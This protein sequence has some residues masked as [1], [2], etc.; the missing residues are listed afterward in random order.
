MT[1]TPS[2]NGHAKLVQRLAALHLPPLAGKR[3]LEIGCG[4]GSACGFAA[5]LGAQAVVGLDDDLAS[6]AQAR[7]RFGHCE[8]HSL[9]ED[10]LPEGRFDV[11][12]LSPLL[13][14]HA[15][16]QRLIALALA[17]LA[18]DGLLVLDAAVASSKASEF[19]SHARAGAPEGHFASMP[20]MREW[21][22]PYAYK[23]LGSS[24]SLAGYPVATHV[25]HIR[26]RRPF[27][28]LLMQPPAFGKSTIGRCLFTPAGVPLVSGDQLLLDI[29]EGRTQ[30]PAPLLA[31]IQ[32]GFSASAI[33]RLGE[34]P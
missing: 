23:H 32:P 16:P 21:L 29:A 31:A 15:E 12:L 30:V 25:F 26:A 8:F 2:A 9:D 24:G 20:L 11:I 3:F 10:R 34:Q 5:H 33:H 19:I 22:A 14:R 18:P 27:A 13:H 4:E 6:V 17:R 28:Y 1:A 7:L